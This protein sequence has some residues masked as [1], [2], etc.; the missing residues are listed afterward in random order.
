MH[1][2]VC[3]T[4]TLQGTFPSD[5]PHRWLWLH[6]ATRGTQALHHPPNFCELPD[7]VAAAIST[8]IREDVFA[9]DVTDA[10]SSSPFGDAPIWRGW[11]M[12]IGPM[13]TCLGAC[14]LMDNV[15]ENNREN[16]CQDTQ[17]VIPTCL[18]TPV[19]ILELGVHVVVSQPWLPGHLPQWLPHR[20]LWLHA[21]TRG[22]QALH[23]PA[24]NFCELPDR[25]AA[26][27]AT[28][29]REDVFAADVT[30]VNQLIP[31]WGLPPAHHHR[32]SHASMHP[33]EGAD[34]TDTEGTGHMGWLSME[35][36]RCF[37]MWD[38][39]CQG[40]HQHWCP[41]PWGAEA[42]VE[43]NSE[44]DEAAEVTDN[45]MYTSPCHQVSMLYIPILATHRDCGS[46]Y[47]HN[48]L[49]PSP[50]MTPQTRILP[51]MYCPCP[52][53]TTL[54]T[55]RHWC[56][57]SPTEDNVTKKVRMPT[58]EEEQADDLVHHS[59]EEH[60]RK[61]H[62]C[63]QSKSRNRRHKQKDKD[64]KPEAPESAM[65]PARYE[66]THYNQRHQE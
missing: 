36:V 62:S 24:L 46:P 39:L 12:V 59:H 29:I 33:S 35:E 58:K 19:L 21:A 34:S 4:L 64:E 54:H 48:P 31:I 66:S 56:W 23:H 30:D 26:A 16:Y 2:V 63:T 41:T 53:C 22:P 32:Q 3:T 42:D 44:E 11:Q 17:V 9:A 61:E 27:I 47:A 38:A 15:E 51:L 6:A 43:D 18:H 1:V 45:I 57:T 20:W 50:R 25:V 37:A 65:V 28:L 49:H 13:D 40:H 60:R 5:Y 52:A 55:A 10:N 8:L 14:T 7:R